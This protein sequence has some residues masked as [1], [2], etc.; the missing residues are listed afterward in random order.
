MSKQY[1]DSRIGPHEAARPVVTGWAYVVRTI[2]H[3]GPK[4][5]HLSCDC[6]PHLV[7][8]TIIY[9]VPGI[10]DSVLQTEKTSPRTSTV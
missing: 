6:T 1:D 3:H 5:M 4:T 7:L 8:I 2:I 10:R 9:L